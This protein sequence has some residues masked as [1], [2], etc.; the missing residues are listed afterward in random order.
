[1]RVT[2]VSLERR[3]LINISVI[4][5]DTD[6][7]LTGILVSTI[8]RCHRHDLSRRFTQHL[9]IKERANDLTLGHCL[10]LVTYCDLRFFRSTCPADSP[11]FRT[12]RLTFAEA[13]ERFVFLSILAVPPTTRATSCDTIAACI[14]AF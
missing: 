8:G 4:C 3:S 13:V 1:M 5:F 11:K 10:L 14:A 7:A 6:A 9:H 2:R 12:L